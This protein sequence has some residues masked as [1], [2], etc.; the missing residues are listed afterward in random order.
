VVTM[1][2]SKGLK[3]FGFDPTLRETSSV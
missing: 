2:N 3:A 1:L